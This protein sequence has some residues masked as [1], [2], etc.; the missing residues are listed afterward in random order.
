MYSMYMHNWWMDHR[1][2]GWSSVQLVEGY[3][4]IALA[5]SISSDFWLGWLVHEVWHGI[6]AYLGFEFILKLLLPSRCPPIGL[7]SHT[8]VSRAVALFRLHVLTSSRHTWG[9]VE[10]YKF[11]CISPFHQF[12]LLVA[13]AS[14]WSLTELSNRLR[15][16]DPMD[17][18]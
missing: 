16:R 4:W 17:A 13:L 15:I 2:S 12:G 8:W 5:L 14:A 18:N 7:S 3:K 6:W 1:S 10:V 11:D 9:G